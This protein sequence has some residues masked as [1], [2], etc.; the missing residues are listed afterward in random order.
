MYLIRKRK[1]LLAFCFYLIVTRGVI[2][3]S[4]LGPIADTAVR[5][6]VSGQRGMKYHGLPILPRDPP[7]VTRQAPRVSVTMLNGRGRF[8]FR[9]KSRFTRLWS[10]LENR[11]SIDIKQNLLFCDRSLLLTIW[12]NYFLSRNFISVIF[13]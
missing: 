5:I 13:L 11:V 4:Q 7:G 1:K 9:K 6:S 8:S 2:D 10:I 12:S 3:K